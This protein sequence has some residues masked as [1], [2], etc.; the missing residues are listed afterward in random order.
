[1]TTRKLPLLL[2]FL[3]VPL[4]SFARGQSTY[5][6]LRDINIR[7]RDVRRLED[8]PRHE[9]TK[10]PELSKEAKAALSPP[11]DLKLGYKDFLKQKNTGLIKLLP[12][13]EENEGMIVSAENPATFIPLRDGGSSYSFS[14]RK[15]GDG[16]VARELRLDKFKDDHRIFL[17]PGGYIGFITALGD[18]A[19]DDVIVDRKEAK[20]LVDLVAPDK[21]Q[22]ARKY[23]EMS[24]TGVDIDGVFYRN[25]AW[26]EEN[27]TYLQRTI[28]YNR[29]DLLVAFRIVRKEPDGSFVILWK[30]LKKNP[31]PV[32]KK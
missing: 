14:N 22:A 9:P 24:V 7:S 28:D 12:R 11:D 6:D 2:L 21:E 3:V 26:A 19:L 17:A 20:F 32:V 10:K 30:I 13:K 25:W 1:M 15:H 23:Q 4:S 8:A 27:T 5:D 29:A 16:F 31:I 18:V